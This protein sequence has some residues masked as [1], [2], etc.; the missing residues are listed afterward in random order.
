M[1]GADV[2]K[3]SS[4]LLLLLPPLKLL[5]WLRTAHMRWQSPS[6]P[7]AS[8][9]SLWKSTNSRFDQLLH[10]LSC[11]PPSFLPW[12]LPGTKECIQ[13]QIQCLESVTRQRRKM[14]GRAARGSASSKDHTHRKLP[15]VV[16]V[17]HL[18]RSLAVANL[19]KLLCCILACKR[20][21]R[22]D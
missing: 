5:I 17:Q 2:I 19:F 16:L 18:L 15:N 10:P 21:K 8:A 11:L 4:K 7:R 20:W 1:Q 12:R 14:V 22:G 6:P 3:W 9:L 13:V